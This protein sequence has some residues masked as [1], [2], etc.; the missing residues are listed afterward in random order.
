MGGIGDYNKGDLRAEAIFNQGASIELSYWN[1][2]VYEVVIPMLVSQ[3]VT[4]PT[5]MLLES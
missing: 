1:L 3:Y 2:A 4:F 5:N